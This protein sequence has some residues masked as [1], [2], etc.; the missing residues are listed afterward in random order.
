MSICGDAIVKMLWLYYR[1]RGPL[2]TCEIWNDEIWCGEIL[3]PIQKMPLQNCWSLFLLTASEWLPGWLPV[4]PGGC[5]A[6]WK[7]ACEES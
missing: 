7:C 4:F 5:W 3:A 6:E 1:G 2:G